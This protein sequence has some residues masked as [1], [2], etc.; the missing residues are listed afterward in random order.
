MEKEYERVLGTLNPE[1]F[2]PLLMRKGLTHFANKHPKTAIKA[3]RLKLKLFEH[4][5]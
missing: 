3:V 4:T 5:I 2:R 1:I